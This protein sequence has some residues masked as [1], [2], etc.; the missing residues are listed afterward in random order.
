M[1]NVTLP[2]GSGTSW[3]VG[4]KRRRGV[5]GS[6][7]NYVTFKDV[8]NGEKVARKEFEARLFIRS[9]HKVHERSHCG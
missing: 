3:G 2:T 1:R 7:I 5:G 8:G 9:L 4:G 6:V